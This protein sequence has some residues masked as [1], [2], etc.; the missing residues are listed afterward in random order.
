M[1]RLN[2]DK[3]Y[4]EFRTGV[5]MTEPVIGRK[6]T[7]THSDITA[8]LFLTIGLQFAYDKVNAMRDE[9]LA[10]WRTNH[11]FPFLYVYVYVDG[12]FGSGVS[13]VRDAIFRRE[14]PLA[15]E[16]IRYGD[17]KFFQTHSDLDNAPIWIHF[18]STN[19]KYN[20][21]ENW[22]TPDDYK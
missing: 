11:G 5:T 18:D 21:F 17:R 3:L 10:E 2:P 9:V 16:A 19:P 22:G 7:L 14:L 20:R 15:L 1:K 13:A 4:V 12:E 8:D 6:Y